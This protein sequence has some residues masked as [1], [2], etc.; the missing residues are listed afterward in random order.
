M[1]VCVEWRGEEGRENLKL[2]G[3]LTINS[4][5]FQILI[6]IRFHERS[7]MGDLE[8]LQIVNHCGETNYIGSLVKQNN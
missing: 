7:E 3:V 4:Y 2:Q 1:C 5:I 8:L 6:K